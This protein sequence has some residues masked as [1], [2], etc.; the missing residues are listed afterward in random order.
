MRV[1]AGAIERTFQSDW[2]RSI[3]DVEHDFPGLG[4]FTGAEMI[5]HLEEIGGRRVGRSSDK[6]FAARDF[7]H[8]RLIELAQQGH[9]ASV[10]VLMTTFR[11]LARSVAHRLAPTA[12]QGMPM[13]H[14]IDA[15]TS[16]LWETIMTY[17]LTRD[18]HVAGNL[19]GELLKRASREFGPSRSH[20]VPADDTLLDDLMSDQSASGVTVGRTAL[21]NLTT[22]L[23]WAV[24]H[25]VVT[26]AEVRLLVGIELADDPGTARQEAADELGLSRDSL[27]RRVHRIR[28]KLMTAVS[29][30]I[31]S[32]VRTCPRRR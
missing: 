31:R 25:D 1:T 12:F 29:G 16:A 22:V 17:P 32:S 3:H 24:S 30:D 21:E 8:H 6:S 2:N 27:N 11:P 7:T 20:E 26:R 5:E 10:S 18:R 9:R 19:R 13:P 4:T 23:M 14:A 28:T 15:A